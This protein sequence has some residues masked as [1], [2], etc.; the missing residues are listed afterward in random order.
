MP[1]QESTLDSD[2]VSNGSPAGNTAPQKPSLRVSRSH[3]S[4]PSPRQMPVIRS[5]AASSRQIAWKELANEDNS[6]DPRPG[7]RYP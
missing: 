1:P 6:L 4:Q 7:P 3:G 5:A 2:L